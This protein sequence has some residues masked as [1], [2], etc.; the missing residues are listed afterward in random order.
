VTGTSSRIFDGD[1]V[2]VSGPGNLFSRYTPNHLCIAVMGP[3]F[4]G[5]WVLYAM[6]RGQSWR[7]GVTG[8]RIVAKKRFD[9]AGRLH[10]GGATSRLR[11]E[12]ADAMW[13]LATFETSARLCWQ[14]TLHR[15]VGAYLRLCSRRI[16]TASASQAR[17]DEFWASFGDL[18]ASGERCCVLLTEISVPV[19]RSQRRPG[20]ILAT[21]SCAGIDLVQRDV[22]VGR[23]RDAQSSKAIL[24]ER[25]LGTGHRRS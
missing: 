20:D 7:I 25:D 24:P 13:L 4:S 1:L 21:E 15:P 14:K 3:A 22:H 11:E 6:R 16:G 9:C 8:P 10:P 17:L 12:D 5:R 23:V 2:T 18:N 19:L